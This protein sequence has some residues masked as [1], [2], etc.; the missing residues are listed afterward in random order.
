MNGWRWERSAS[1]TFQHLSINTN[2]KELLFWHINVWHLKEASTYQLK[3]VS[4]IGHRQHQKYQLHE[5][6]N[7]IDDT[8]TKPALQDTGLLS[9]AKPA[10]SLHE[11]NKSFVHSFLE[12]THW[13]Q[14]WMQAS[15]I[16]TCYIIYMASSATLTVTNTK[17]NIHR[18]INKVNQ[19]SAF[20]QCCR[21]EKA[22]NFEKHIKAGQSNPVHQNNEG[23]QFRSIDEVHKVLKHLW[24]WST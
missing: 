13:P 20:H 5:I 12:H 18:N 24:S 7:P 4:T 2:V 3:D 1:T 21:I 15:T 8:D 19:H 16:N 17:V 23:A 9:Y 22:S 10:P 14:W 6:A 11:V